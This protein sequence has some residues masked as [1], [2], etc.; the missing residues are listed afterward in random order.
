MPAKGGV[1]PGRRHP[2]ALALEPA[3]GLGPV[4][5]A[6]GSHDRLSSSSRRSPARW[7]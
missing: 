1:D 4:N 5:R 6:S 2:V 7:A 3:P